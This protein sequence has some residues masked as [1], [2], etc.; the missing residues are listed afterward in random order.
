M[1]YIKLKNKCHSK[2]RYIFCRSRNLLRNDI[3]WPFTLGENKFTIS[4]GFYANNTI[5]TYND[6]SCHGCYKC[7][8]FQQ[9]PVPL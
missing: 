3:D 4:T 1:K 9:K 7:K 8:Y 6:S 5:V 2:C